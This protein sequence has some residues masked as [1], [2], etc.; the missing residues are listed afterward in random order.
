MSTALVAGWKMM[1]DV[2]GSQ[3]MKGFQSNTK[4]RGKVL[5]MNTE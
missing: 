2:G 1:E 5:S 3:T 4:L